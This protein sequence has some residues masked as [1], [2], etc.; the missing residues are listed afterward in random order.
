[1]NNVKATTKI[2]KLKQTSALLADLPFTGTDA[3]STSKLKF[4]PYKISSILATFFN[5]S[6][7]FSSFA[8]QR[9]SAIVTPIY[10]TCNKADINNYKSIS[11]LPL[12]PTIFEKAVDR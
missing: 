6:I 5:T 4:F 7:A 11:I 2:F 12:A 3:I 10:K 9:K 1:M 8:E